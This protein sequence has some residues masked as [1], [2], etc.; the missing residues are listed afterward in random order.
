MF[1]F[2]VV[3]VAQREEEE[4]PTERIFF[5]RA[6]WVSDMATEVDAWSSVPQ[7]DGEYANA[8]R[9]VVFPLLPC[10]YVSPSLSLL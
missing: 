8:A 2:F 4:Q 7:V 6:H 3:V 10:V 5:N 9:R 1:V